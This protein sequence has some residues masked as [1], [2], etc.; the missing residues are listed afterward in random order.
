MEFT[1]QTKAMSSAF[2]EKIKYEI[3]GK[4]MKITLQHPFVED[5]KGMKVQLYKFDLTVKTL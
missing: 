4:K 1:K 5:F 3:K 2:G